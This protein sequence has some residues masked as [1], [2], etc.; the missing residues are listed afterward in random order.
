MILNEQANKPSGN[1]APDFEL[2]GVDGKVH[3][4]STYLDTF[5]A[6]AVIFMC[7]H[8]P[9]V[10]LYLNRLKQIQ[11]KFANENFTLI[12]INANDSRQNPEDSFVGMQHFALQQELNFPYLWDSSQD[13]A[14]SFQAKTTPEVFLIDNSGLICYQGAIDDNPTQ[15][16]LVRKP[17]LHDSIVALLA[18]ENITITS[19]KAIGSSLKWRQLS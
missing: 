19:Q 8:C 2:P 5:R 12:G 9:Q 1:H 3:H 6:I 14:V 11:A 10:E 16:E 4:L 15:P 13:V 7:N 18:G 17:Y